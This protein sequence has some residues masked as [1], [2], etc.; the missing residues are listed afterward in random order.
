M[1]KLL[2]RKVQLRHVT[3]CGEDPQVS[4]KDPKQCQGITVHLR[5]EP[6]SKLE[7][8]Y[9]VNQ[10]VKKI[11]KNSSARKNAL[12]WIWGKSSVLDT[13]T[14]GRWRVY[15]LFVSEE[16]SVSY[17]ALLASKQAE[18]VEIQILSNEKLS[19]LVQSSDHQGLVAR[20]SKYPYATVDSFEANLVSVTTAMSAIRKP[21]VV[22]VDRVQDIFNF[23][24]ILRCCDHA[25]V[26][27]IVVGEHCQSQVTTQVARLSLGAVN[28]LSI[29]QSINLQNAVRKIKELGFTLV[30]ADYGTPTSLSE[31]LDTATFESPIAIVIGSD[32]QAIDSGLLALCDRRISI[33]ALGNATPLSP[34]ISAGILMYEIRRQQR[35]IASVTDAS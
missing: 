35:K 32:V 9:M 6:N 2:S 7:S 16:A 24:S 29:V 27:G 23:A 3:T 34:S 19:A 5:D 14:A 4:L 15:E 20:V 26:S 28:H 33:P 11:R 22:I 25:G 10:P 8:D 13:V 31:N 1:N 17:S 30:T 12:N 18:G 21:I